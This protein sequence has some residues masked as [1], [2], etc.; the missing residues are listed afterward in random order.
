MTFFP[1]F[2]TDL[3]GQ[4]IT[5]PSD[6]DPQYRIQLCFCTYRHSIIYF[7]P[8]LEKKVLPSYLQCFGKV[9]ILKRRHRIVK[10]QL[11]CSCI[12]PDLH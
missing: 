5:D 9:K 11:L 2:S 8:R 7:N 10:M 12:D 4:L 3:R 1:F 6:L